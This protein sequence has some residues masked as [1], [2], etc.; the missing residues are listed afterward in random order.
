M[1]EDKQALLPF[2]TSP[3][4]PA[5]E[6]TYTAEWDGHLAGKAR[7]TITAKAEEIKTDYSDLTQLAK[8]TEFVNSIDKR[9]DAQV[10]KTYWVYESE[11]SGKFISMI[12]PHEWNDTSAKP[13]SYL[14][15]YRLSP[16]GTWIK[17]SK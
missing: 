6:V 9:F 1:S 17:E 16:D 5:I 11:K 2:G 10:G 14:G 7:D 3:S 8:D 12:E 15:Q 4:F 13:T